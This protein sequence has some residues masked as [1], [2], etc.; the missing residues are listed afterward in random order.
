MISSGLS[1][2]RKVPCSAVTATRPSL[3]VVVDEDAREVAAVVLAVLDPQRHLAAEGGELADLDRGAERAGAQLEAQ[4]LIIIARIGLD[5]ADDREIERGEGERIHVG[6][7]QQPAVA[8]SRPRAA[9]RAPTGRE[10]AEGEQNAE[11]QPDRNAEPQIFGKQV[12]EHP[13]NHADRPA[14]VRDELEQPQHA[15]EHQQHRRDEQRRDQRHRDQPRHVAIEQVHALRRRPCC[16][17]CQRRGRRSHQCASLYRRFPN[18]PA[19]MLREL[20]T[21]SRS[22][23]SPCPPRG[24][25]RGSGRSARRYARRTASSAAR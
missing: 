6:D 3:V 10:A 25:S 24:T 7:A 17:S 4:P 2:R 13:P 18:A 22:R 8:E 16:S 21:L 23:R 20:E 15:I 11:H 12:G 1:V 9:R 14:L 19:R 5:E